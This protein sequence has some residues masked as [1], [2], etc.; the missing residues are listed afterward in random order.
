MESNETQTQLFYQC[1]T[2]T[3]THTLLIALK[4]ANKAVSPRSMVS[5]CLSFLKS[6]IISLIACTLSEKGY[7]MV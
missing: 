5:N 1:V 4:A 6:I 2:H 3:R 7:G